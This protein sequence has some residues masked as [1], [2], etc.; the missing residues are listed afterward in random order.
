MEKESNIFKISKKTI[1]R[2]IIFHVVVIIAISIP[3]KSFKK[4]K[5]NNLT[6]NNI[7]VQREITPKITQRPQL[8]KPVVQKVSKPVLKQA[9]NKA[10]ATK[11]T[12]INK[13]ENQIQNLD[14]TKTT[15]TKKNDLLV[16]KNIKS[17]DIDK[18]II[19]ETKN[20]T[21]FKQLLVNELQSN[22]KLLEYGD[23]KVSFIIHPSGEITDIVIL[24]SQS[25][26]NQKYLKN[27]LPQIQFKNVNKMFVEKQKLIVTFKNE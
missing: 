16:P 3:Y 25:D 27:N 14:K 19:N 12:L 22:L 5:K 4:E 18:K 2:V 9:N 6:V 13:L 24:N 23:V 1:K 21:D 20:T 7:T 15:I 17:I 8:K 10:S 11:N 26:I